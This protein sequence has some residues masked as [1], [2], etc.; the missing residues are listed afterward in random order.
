MDEWFIDSLE[1]EIATLPSSIMEAEDVAIVVP[2]VIMNTLVLTP[3]CCSLDSCVQIDSVFMPQNLDMLKKCVQSRVCVFLRNV[4]HSHYYTNRYWLQVVTEKKEPVVPLKCVWDRLQ[5]PYYILRKGP[6]TPM[7]SERFHTYGHNKVS[8]MNNLIVNNYR[9]YI[10]T[11]TF[12]V[13][14]AHR[15]SP[16]K[17][18]SN[19]YFRG[20]NWVYDGFLRELGKDIKKPYNLPLCSQLP[21]MYSLH[22]SVY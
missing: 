8:H 2:L 5:E 21:L 4:L 22:E 3:R 6:N 20:M 12:L 18:Y 15:P 13:D 1:S 11:H 7:Y 16:T 14:I 10:M 19:K 17:L 9:F